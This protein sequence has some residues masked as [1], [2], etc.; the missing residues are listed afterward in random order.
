MHFVTPKPANC[1][2]M[3][4]TELAW[5]AGFFDGEGTTAYYGDHVLRLSAGQ[6]NTEVLERFNST[7]WGMGKIYGPN[8]KGQ[9]QLIFNGPAKV[10]QVVA[11][12]WS[13]LDTVKKEQA[14][15]ALNRWKNNKNKWQACL[16]IGHDIRKWGNK[17]TCKTCW[18]TK[19]RSM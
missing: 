3:T 7:M 16:S 9:Y 17:R 2:H 10:Q 19:W 5:C 6:K 18:D 12:M 1:P 11:M 15:S 13:Y 4:K 14:A 8:K